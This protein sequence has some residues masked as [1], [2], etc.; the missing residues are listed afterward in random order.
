MSKFTELQQ[1]EMVMSARALADSWEKAE[2][3]SEEDIEKNLEALLGVME[4]KLTFAE[5]K[6]ET[7]VP[8]DRSR[9]N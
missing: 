6:F 1:E 4:G 3:L 2:T 5:F 8:P 9:S 7:E